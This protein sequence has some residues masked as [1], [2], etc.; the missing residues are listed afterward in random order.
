[1]RY[2]C[3]R[4][5]AAICFVLSG[6]PMPTRITQ[7]M[8]TEKEAC[9]LRFNS[10]DALISRRLAGFVLTLSVTII[11]ATGLSAQSAT[12]GIFEGQQDVG[13]ILHPGSAVY[14]ASTGTYTLTGSG[15]NIWWAEDDFHY[16]WKKVSGDFSLSADVALLGKGGEPHRKAVL[17]V[18]QSLDQDSAAVGVAVHGDGLT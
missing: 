6:K 10:M 4:L 15:D 13:V 18:R 3:T 17:M 1:M 16:V 7:I 9:R 2:A 8:A 5:E 14:D 12:L 11:S